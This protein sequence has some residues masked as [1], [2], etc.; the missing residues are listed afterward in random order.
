MP[1][2]VR[3]WDMLERFSLPAADPYLAQGHE[4]AWIFGGKH[5]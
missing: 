2:E 3:L 5:M 4:D 1:S